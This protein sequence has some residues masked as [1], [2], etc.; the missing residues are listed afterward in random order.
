MRPLDTARK[1]KAAAVLC[2]KPLLELL[3]EHKTDANIKGVYKGQWRTPLQI[4]IEKRHV[5]LVKLLQ[6]PPHAGPRATSVV[7]E[8]VKN[9]K[10]VSK[11]A[12]MLS[13]I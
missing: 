2:T 3:L 10:L 5:D 11:E 13:W 9:K 12:F 4:A 7:V 8:M 1:R 6:M